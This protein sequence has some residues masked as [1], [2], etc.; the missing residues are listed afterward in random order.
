MV[1]NKSSSWY[2]RWSD[3]VALEVCTV[4]TWGSKEA[5]QL[6]LSKKKRKQWAT[7]AQLHMSRHSSRGLLSYC[8]SCIILMMLAQNSSCD[9]K[10]IHRNSWTLSAN[11]PCSQE[12][13]VWKDL[14][15]LFLSSSFSSCSFHNH[16]RSIPAKLRNENISCLEGPMQ[17]L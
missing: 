7:S 1:W 12:N 9:S 14:K 2:L 11:T 4:F 5:N 13:F 6:L 10:E 17:A 15:P 8:C 16:W 3:Q